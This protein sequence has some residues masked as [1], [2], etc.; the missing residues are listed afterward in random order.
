MLSNVIPSEVVGFEARQAVATL[1][2]NRPDSA[3]AINAELAR[4]LRDAALRCSDD[5]G[6]RA[7]VL[8]AEGSMFCGGSDLKSFAAQASISAHLKQVT[9]DLYAASSYLPRVNAPLVAAVQGFAAG[10]GL[11]LAL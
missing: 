6:T 7:V 8:Q 11:S 10:G 4:E 2:L 1:T 5:P 3:N 9:T